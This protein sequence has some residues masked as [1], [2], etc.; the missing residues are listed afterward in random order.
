[1]KVAGEIGCSQSLTDFL[2]YWEN[3]LGLLFKFDRREK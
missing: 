2:D 3:E 1:M